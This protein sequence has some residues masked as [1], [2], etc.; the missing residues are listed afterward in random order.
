M[1]WRTQV[2]CVYP[3]PV[4][5]VILFSQVRPVL[6]CGV[7]GLA[8]KKGEQQRVKCTR[9]AVKCRFLHGPSAQ[10]NT[11][12]DLLIREQSLMDLGWAGQ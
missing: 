8:Q 12:W 9:E 10:F 4:A 2:I 7:C 3:L 11:N 6:L 5:P 1:P